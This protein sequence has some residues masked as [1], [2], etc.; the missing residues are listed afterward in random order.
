MARFSLQQNMQTFAPPYYLEL[1]LAQGGGGGGG[2]VGG[3]Q[4][5]FIQVQ[6][7]TYTLVDT[8]F[9]TKKVPLLYTF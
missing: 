4:Q 3:T 8:I 2:G 6:P 5:M 7:L 9:L 1:F